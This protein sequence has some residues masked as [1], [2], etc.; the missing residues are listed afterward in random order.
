MAVLVAMAR[1]GCSDERMK[2]VLD[3]P[4][5]EH[6]RDQR[7]PERY[8][9]RQIETAR[10][11]AKSKAEKIR[12]SD[13]LAAAQAI[14]RSKFSDSSGTP[15][16]WR[17]RGAFWQW[18]GSYFRQRSDE[19]VEMAVWSF[20]RESQD[21]QGNGRRRL[22]ISRSKVA[23]IV[24]ALK[25]SILLPDDLELPSWI[26]DA[27]HTPPSELFACKNGLLHLATGELQTPSARFFNMTASEVAFEPN[28][29]D[30]PGWLAFLRDLFGDDAEAASTLQEW[31]GYCLSYDTSPQKMLLLIGPK[32][33]GKGTIARVLQLLLGRN[34][35]AGPTMASLSAAFGL[36]PLITKSV[37]II[38]DARIG[39][40]TDKSAI[41]ER[42]LSISGEDTLSVDRKFKEAWHGKLGTRFMILTNELPSFS[43]GA[44]A[45]SGRFIVL[46]LTNSF[47][48]NEDAHLIDKLAQELPG[49]LNWAIEG[50]RRLRARR[51]FQQPA[52]GREALDEIE[53]LGSPVKAF[54][55]DE[56]QVHPG[57]TVTATALWN[58]YCSWASSEGIKLPG[59]KTWFGRN[60]RS[61][62]PGIVGK[63]LG[64][65]DGRELTYVGISLIPDEAKPM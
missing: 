2:I 55:R 8:L 65:N 48:G 19:Y 4:I 63:K 53:M 1:A 50:Y 18:T 32:R 35:V 29:A 34:S 26:D 46:N 51:R 52:S 62:L 11:F 30:P 36:E 64:P 60:L 41:M 37:G 16:L 5:G 23:D 3:L 57:G 49:I 58:R 39:A 47:F 42:L 10:N 20:L 13:P 61:A 45:L 56:C 40:R 24:A 6:V 33:S 31:F 38:S 12:L 43:D 9:I 22:K 44:G 54:I 17:Y 25:S 21:A 7:D 59:T 27:A 15:T 28:V 14:L